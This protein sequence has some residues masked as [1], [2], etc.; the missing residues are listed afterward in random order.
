M[1]G[2]I[3]D[4]TADEGLV[5]LNIDNDT[6]C[7]K[8]DSTHRSGEFLLEYI[9]K[10]LSQNSLKLSDIDYVGAINGPGSFTGIRVG[11]S[12]IKAIVFALNK[13]LIIKNAF[14]VVASRVPCCQVLIPCTKTST[15]YGNIVNGTLDNY[16]VKN[17][18]ELVCSMPVIIADRRPNIDIK[19]QVIE[20]W[21]QMLADYFRKCAS[22]GE[23]IELN[24]VAPFYIQLSQAERTELG[25]QN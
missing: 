4:V 1:K 14:E 13:K 19:A 3:I 7:V 24:K 10:I 11:L 23:F 20:N 17:N 12:T 18:D 16:G 15:Y 25:K 8:L 9:D 2:L 6:K 21:E 22:N 5:I